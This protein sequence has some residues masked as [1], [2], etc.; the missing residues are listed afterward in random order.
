MSLRSEIKQVVHR[1]DFLLSDRPPGSIPSTLII[2]NSPTINA[3]LL[4]VMCDHSSEIVCADG[5]ANRLHDALTD[6]DLRSRHIPE[7]ICGDFDSIRQDVL[8]FYSSQG[9]R[10]EQDSDQDSNDLDKCL[11]VLA[12][13]VG[14]FSQV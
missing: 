1:S 11:A 6:Q 7:L 8:A 10:V 13:G 3:A 12:R 5:G 2:V 14:S 4:R 9:S